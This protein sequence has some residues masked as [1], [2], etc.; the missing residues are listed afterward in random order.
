M[1]RMLGPASL[2]FGVVLSVM[3]AGCGGK[4]NEEYDASVPSAVD[5]DETGNLGSS[6]NGTAMGLQTVNFAYDTFTLDSRAKS[7]LKA[8]ADILKDKVTL[9]IQIEGHCDERGSIQYNLALG[10]K[11]A[12]ATRDYLMDMGIA[13]DRVSIIS[14]GE[15]KPIDTGSG[16][17][18]WARNRRANFVITAQ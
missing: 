2:A 18:A 11:R 12:R 1:K 14:F 6:D 10:E 9:A 3:I 15:E 5:A 7:I 4:K 13:G 8:N 16:D 17:A